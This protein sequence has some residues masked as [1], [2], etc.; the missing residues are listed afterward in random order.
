[1]K[2]VVVTSLLLI[3]LALILTEPALAKITNAEIKEASKT[4]VST[5]NDWTPGIMGGGFLLAATMF[6]LNKYAY[7]LGAIGGT[8]IVYAAKAF[9]GDGSGAL[10]D[11]ARVLLG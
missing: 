9:V 3:A 5:I 7:A 11:L 1:M 2:K 4:W 10:V 6:F 8:G